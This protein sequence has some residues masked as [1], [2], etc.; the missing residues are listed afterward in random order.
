[1]QPQTARQSILSSEAMIADKANMRECIVSVSTVCFSR[2]ALFAL[3]II[4]RY[5]CITHSLQ[6][7]GLKYQAVGRSRSSPNSSGGITNLSNICGVI[8]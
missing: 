2:A 5:N 4:L 8:K 7:E 1:M 3:S 6:C